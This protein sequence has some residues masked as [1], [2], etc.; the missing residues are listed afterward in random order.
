MVKLRSLNK[1]KKSILLITCLII[2]TTCAGCET[3]RGASK[4]I[5]N[6]ARNLS[7]LLR[8]GKDIKDSSQ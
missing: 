4:D 6:T 1:M 8:L 3:M 7:D 5:G 2:M